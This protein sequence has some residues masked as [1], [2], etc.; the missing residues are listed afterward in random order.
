[1]VNASKEGI[2]ARTKDIHK[3]RALVSIHSFR[4]D[5]EETVEGQETLQRLTGVFHYCLQ[6]PDACNGKLMRVARLDVIITHLGGYPRCGSKCLLTM[7]SE[8]TRQEI[9]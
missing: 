7:R 5:V 6:V 9:T 8:V 4:K 3:N 2:D 1:M